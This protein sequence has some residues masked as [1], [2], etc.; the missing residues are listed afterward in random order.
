MA[1]FIFLL[2]RTVLLFCIL[3]IF[4]VAFPP[5]VDSEKYTDDGFF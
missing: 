4:Y 3:F 5:R 2:T 1:T